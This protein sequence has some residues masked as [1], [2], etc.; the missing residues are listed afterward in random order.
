MPAESQ[1]PA[2]ATAV[3]SALPFGVAC[4]PMDTPE[5]EQFVERI[6]ANAAR[7]YRGKRIVGISVQSKDGSYT[8]SFSDG[9]T[10]AAIVN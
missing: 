7:N 9:T 10:V 6:A 8:M 3:S 4:G 1:P 2:T 5:C